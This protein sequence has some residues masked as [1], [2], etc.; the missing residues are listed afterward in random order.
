M[1]ISATATRNGVWRASC[2]ANGW[3]NVAGRCWTTMHGVAKSGGKP[4]STLPIA[5]GPPV[6]APMITTP[7]VVLGAAF[8]NGRGGSGAVIAAGARATVCAVA[9]AV[10]VARWRTAA[11]TFTLL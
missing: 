1:P 4:A 6:E 3:V 5:R 8:T 10:A 11:A 2:T 7:A 9:E